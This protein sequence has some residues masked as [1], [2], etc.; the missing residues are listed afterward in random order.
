MYCVVKYTDYKKSNSFEI[1][2]CI[3]DKELAFETAHKYAETERTKYKY[4]YV[5][6]SNKFDNEYVRC[7]K[8]IKEFRCITLENNTDKELERLKNEYGIKEKYNVKDY[9]DD[10]VPLK[11]KSKE[12]TLL[13]DLSN[14]ELRD[15]L[16]EYRLEHIDDHICDIDG[17][18][19]I[20][21]QSAT[22]YAV[23]KVK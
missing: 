21:E 10:D 22:I 1:L 3:E 13:K 16:V 9:F 6:S 4:Q 7:K 5:V 17:V 19:H 15:M 2:N 23:V 18:P 14:E 11:Y 20:K 12:T 8:A